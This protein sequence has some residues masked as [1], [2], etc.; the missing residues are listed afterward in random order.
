MLVY[1]VNKHVSH[2]AWRE[3]AIRVDHVST[4]FHTLVLIG[5]LFLSSEMKLEFQIMPRIF[6]LLIEL[7]KELFMDFERSIV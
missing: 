5:F 6:V 1:K 4:T 3:E 7:F 2:Y